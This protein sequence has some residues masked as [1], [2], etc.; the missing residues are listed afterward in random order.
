MTV[1]ALV[2][3]TEQIRGRE[4]G[5]TEAHADYLSI[6]SFA[7]EARTRVTHPAVCVTQTRGRS[8]I[9]LN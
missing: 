7:R 4:E 9:A 2:G 6:C 5:E 3:Y 1:V 8:G